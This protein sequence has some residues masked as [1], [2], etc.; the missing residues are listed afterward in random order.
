MTKQRKRAFLRYTAFTALIL[1]A[2][3]SLALT[4]VR[5]RIASYSYLFFTTLVV[6]TA[7]LSAHK[8]ETGRFID[9]KDT[10]NQKG[11]KLGLKNRK[12]AVGLV[13]G[14]LILVLGMIIGVPAVASENLVTTFLASSIFF[15]GYIVAH[16]SATKELL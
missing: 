2:S 15:S 10:Q 8:V 1:I 3:F 12:E 14:G 7:Y 4:A 13:A 6:W 5:A 9:G 11:N 16:Y